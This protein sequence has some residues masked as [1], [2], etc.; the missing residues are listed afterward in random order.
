MNTEEILKTA[1]ANLPGHW[2][3][4][5]YGDGVDK[6]C[7]MGHVLYATGE[8]VNQNVRTGTGTRW[9]T[10]ASYT[11]RALHDVLEE[12]YPGVY[13]VP[14]WNDDPERTEE[15]VIAILEKAIAK[16]GEDAS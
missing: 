16:A 10:E 3:Q 9:V 7:L 11:I 1:K 5:G 4:G 2:H 6:L 13:S 12:Q 14:D 8:D 15:E